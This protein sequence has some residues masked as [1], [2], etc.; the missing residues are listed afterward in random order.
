MTVYVDPNMRR[1]QVLIV[2]N[3]RY[4][5]PVGKDIKL[6]RDEILA[7]MHEGKGI[8]ESQGLATKI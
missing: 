5:V 1:E 7:G 3:K 4:D 6:F 8:N 2:N